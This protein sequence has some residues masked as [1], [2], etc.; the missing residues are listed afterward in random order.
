VPKGKRREPTP[1][2]R[3]VWAIFGLP[4]E[5]I[6]RRRRR[7]EGARKAAATRKANRE[8]AAAT[9]KANREKAAATRKANREKAAAT[10]KANREAASRL[11]VTEPPIGDP[12]DSGR[13]TT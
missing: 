12:R 2:Q 1:A 8:K 6:E 4:K 10:R 7:S 3:L 13:L 9:R 5:E 11:P